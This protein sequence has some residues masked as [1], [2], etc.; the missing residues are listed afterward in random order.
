MYVTMQQVLGHYATT[1]QWLPTV[2]QRL[3][4]LDV[5]LKNDSALSYSYDQ[6]LK[7]IS[8]VASTVNSFHYHLGGWLKKLMLNLDQPCDLPEALGTVF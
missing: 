8:T 1:D 7:Y 4:H 2:H 5:K 6:Y 3:P